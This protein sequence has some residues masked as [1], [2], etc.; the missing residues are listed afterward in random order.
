MMRVFQHES[1]FYAG[2][3]AV[4]RK[5]LSAVG[6]SDVSTRSRPALSRS[7]RGMAAAISPAV[8]FALA[9]LACG[10][11]FYDDVSPL[12]ADFAA[13]TAVDDGTA[14]VPAPTWYR[15]VQP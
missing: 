4:R 12:P 14:G 13:C 9:F 8:R 1:S 15:D 10:A 11:C 3:R 7:W 2:T 6:V 5:R